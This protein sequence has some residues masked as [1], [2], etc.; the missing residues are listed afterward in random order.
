M[1]H[2]YV[3][4]SFSISNNH[5]IQNPKSQS[6][7]IEIKRPSSKR[8]I[9]NKNQV[10]YTIEKYGYIKDYGEKIITFK[11]KSTLQIEKNSMIQIK[12]PQLNKEENENKKTSS[13]KSHLN[14]YDNKNSKPNLIFETGGRISY[15]N[16]NTF[17]NIENNNSNDNNIVKTEPSPIYN[18]FTIETQNNYNYRTKLS[19]SDLILELMKY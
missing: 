9:C 18:K 6:K 2:N 8:K 10:E 15:K 1:E 4:N 19:Y 3:Q 13:H 12:N 11:P 14:F 17:N 5:H 7:T 16:V